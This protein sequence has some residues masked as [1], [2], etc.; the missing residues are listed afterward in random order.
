[1]KKNT[2]KK[3]TLNRETVRALDDRR[4]AEALGQLSTNPTCGPTQISY[5]R[6]CQDT[7][8]EYN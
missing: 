5:C 7:G 1:M 8:P 4:L 2:L 3:L 6:V